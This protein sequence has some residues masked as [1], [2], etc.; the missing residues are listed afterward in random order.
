MAGA[1][2]PPS[3]ESGVQTLE[4]DDIGRCQPRLEPTALAMMSAAVC[5]LC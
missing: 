1:S 2:T 4:Q 3:T 5:S